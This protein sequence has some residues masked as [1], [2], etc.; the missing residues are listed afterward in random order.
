M[1]I[2]N[3]LS[4][5]FGYIFVVNITENLSSSH[6]KIFDSYLNTIVLKIQDDIELARL[7]DTIQPRTAALS[8]IHTIHRLISSTLSEKELLP[9]LARL[10]LQVMRVKRCTIYLTDR[11]RKFMKVAVC[12]TIYGEA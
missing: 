4:W 10:T 3:K 12:V 7:Y 1:S 9:R 2:I 8:T 5:I 6:L 11:N